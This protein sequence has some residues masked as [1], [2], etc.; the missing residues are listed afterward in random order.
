MR[1]IHLQELTRAVSLLA[2]RPLGMSQNREIK[3]D[4]SV[5]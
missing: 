3:F 2:L 4:S 1:F 5:G